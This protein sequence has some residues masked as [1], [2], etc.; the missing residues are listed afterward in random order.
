[1]LLEVYYVGGA[2]CILNIDNLIKIGIDPAL[3]PEGTKVDFKGFTSIRR[4]GPY[5]E[6]GIFDDIDIW[7]V[8]HMHEDH[9]DNQ[10]ID[11]I[12]P[13]SEVICES[14]NTFHSINNTKCKVLAW[15]NV[16]SF[17]KKDISVEIVS[18]PAFHA[19]NFIVRNSI[20][21]INGYVLKIQSRKIRKI[22]YFTGDTI[23]S[24]RITG[25]IP[26]N[27]DI[28]VAN[29]G[30]ARGSKFFGPLTMDLKMLDK[31]AESIEPQIIVPIHIDDFSHYEMTKKQ[32][33]D[34]GYKLFPSGKWIALT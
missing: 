18:V 2:T 10:G 17:I 31:F 5:I 6:E 14:E 24:K 26:P 23:F 4:I 34:A 3:A 22:I 19:K 33:Q 12:S 32:V 9:L 16:Y 11:V 15:G 30:N 25:A 7:L 8:T 13:S 21:Q 1:M 20:G 29:L 28:M 27:I